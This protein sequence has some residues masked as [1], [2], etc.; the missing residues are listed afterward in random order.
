MAE[1]GQLRWAL[2]PLAMVPRGFKSLSARR[3]V[4]GKQKGRVGNNV[5]FSSFWDDEPMRG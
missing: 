4:R 2:D 1:L 5:L 3:P